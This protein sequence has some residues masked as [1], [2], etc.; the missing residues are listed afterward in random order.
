MNVSYLPADESETET[1][2]KKKSILIDF[3]QKHRGEPDIVIR[4]LISP[5]YLPCQLLF[6]CVAFRSE[7]LK[8]MTSQG[9][10][11]CRRHSGGFTLKTVG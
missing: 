3:H 6:E 4:N 5:S 9:V 10:F 8:H 2:K 11:T 1:E 7:C